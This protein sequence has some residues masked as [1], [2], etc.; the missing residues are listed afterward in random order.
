MADFLTFCQLNLLDYIFN[1]LYISTYNHQRVFY[2][3]IKQ[4]EHLMLLSL[5]LSL[6]C[7]L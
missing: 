4:E 3:L 1:Y 7:K 6:S 2:L 5:L